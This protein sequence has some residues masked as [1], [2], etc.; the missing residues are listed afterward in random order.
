MDM[1]FESEE[2]RFLRPVVWEN[3]RQEQ[4]QEIR[5][6]DDLPDAGRVLGCWGQ[7]ILRS[8]EWRSGGMMASGGVM[9]WTL[10]APEDGSEPRCVE[11]W[12]PFQIKWNFPATETDGLMSVCCTLHSADA[13][14]VSARKLM[15]RVS[16]N[17]LGIGTCSE[18]A[19][20]FTPGE[21]PED[22]ELLCRT[23]PVSLPVEA[24]EKTVQLDEE[25]E[26]PGNGQDRKLLRC[27]L[28]PRLQEKRIVGDRLVFRGNGKLHLLLMDGG[29]VRS[30]TLDVPFSAFTDLDREYGEG[31]CAQI[32]FAVTAME[33]EITEEGH[34][35]L[36]AGL[37]A[38]YIMWDRKMLDIVEDAWSH[39][40]DIR[41]QQQILMLPALL[42]H[43]MENCTA[44]GKAHQN[45]AVVDGVCFLDNVSARMEE[46]KMVLTVPA[47]IQ[48]LGREENGI[49]QG[50]NAQLEGRISVMQEEGN[51]VYA[52]PAEAGPVQAS[53]NGTEMEIHCDLSVSV[54]TLSGQGITM[55]SGMELGELRP[56]DPDRPSVILRRCMGESLW[57]MAKA[58]GSTVDAIREA[59]GLD[60]EPEKGR[61]L[62]IPVQ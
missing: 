25:M 62:L 56:A 2:I 14:V 60:E 16:V 31:G 51:L 24:G 20:V 61:M 54:R 32:D 42:E 53:F 6:T 27:L 17:A 10:Y 44:A 29:K 46:G 4:T 47:G 12:V 8:K 7:C 36:K 39:R 18:E 50:T 13:R 48:L 19:A 11:N 9:V 57:E 26:L 58:G 3:Q 1:K 38:Q 5:L 33:A 41:L 37:A 55:V 21:V 40:R 23:Y 45:M 34:L 22:V 35:R 52:S 28:S 15:L 43:R 59:N 30:E 49:H